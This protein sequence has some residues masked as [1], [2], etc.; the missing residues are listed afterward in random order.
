MNHDSYGVMA[1]C[2]DGIT[3]ALLW[4]II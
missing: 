1:V 2:P 4:V 3:V